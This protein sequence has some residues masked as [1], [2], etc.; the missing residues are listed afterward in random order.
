MAWKDTRKM[1]QKMEFVKKSIHCENFRQLC[2][3][4]GIS[5]KTGYKW[6]KR[7]LEHGEAGL[8]EK[9][10]R[11]GSH[12]RQLGEDVVCEIVRLKR[13]HPHW[14]PRK[15]RALYGRKHPAEIPSESSF[16]RV[17]EKAGLVKA[18]RRRKVVGKDSRRL[19]S[20]VKAG[21]PN[22]VWS[23][24]FKGWWKDAGG[25]RVEPLTVRDE[26]SRMILELCLV[27]STRTETIKA[28]FERLFERFGLPGAIRSDNGPPF[29]SPQGLLGLSRLS[30][31]WLALGIQLERGRPGHP[32]DN[33]AHERMHGDI[34]R[35]LEREGAGR[36]QDAFDIWRE[37][38]NT[39]RP[40]EALGMATPSEIHRPSERRYE[41]TP[42]DLDY[43]A[44]TTR[45]V[46]SN[47]M[48]SFRNESIRISE[49]LAGWSVGLRPAAEGR[50][51]E[52][53]FA[54]LLLG[55]IDPQVSAFFAAKPP[56]APPPGPA[57][58]A[59]SSG[60]ATL[61]RSKARRVTR[62]AR[63]SPPKV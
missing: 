3:Q 13:A 49:S 33:G 61:R 60:S 9:S 54:E 44:L 18:R 6:R 41:G 38:Y 62:K 30:V 17:L 12:G 23:V 20:G 51:H 26:F 46:G 43:G 55:H 45:R 16:K 59:P 39:V 34:F 19:A 31:W 50:I 32:E 56:A 8:K 63:Q 22:E 14:G 1:D 28:C 36:D 10:R 27:E 53:Y 57:A 40:H 21:A 25:L 58:A 11:P 4:Y 24:D 2:R 47:G 15:I 5:A 7:F 37:E 35:E 29:A 48:I 42:E 52:V